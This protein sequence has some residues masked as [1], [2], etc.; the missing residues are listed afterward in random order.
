MGTPRDYHRRL[1]AQ[2]RD[3]LDVALA[4]PVGALLGLDLADMIR[5]RIKDRA[6]MLAHQL[7]AGDDDV[8][9]ETVQ[10]VMIALWPAGDPPDEWW[11]TPL[12]R[13]CAASL[14]IDGSERISASVAAARL[15]VHPSRIYQ[16]IH[17]GKLERHPESGVTWAS[18][19]NQ[20]ASRGG[21]AK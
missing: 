15:G 11:R 8:A 9:A 7:T 2:I 17:E 19:A 21:V 1:V 3:E 6:D 18:V 5:E 4:G 12:G 10:D 16:M 20:L 13:A 14:G